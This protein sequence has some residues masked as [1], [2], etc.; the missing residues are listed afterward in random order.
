MKYLK[1]IKIVFIIFTIFEYFNKMKFSS[2]SYMPYIFWGLF[3]VYALIYNYNDENKNINLISKI[4]AFFLSFLMFLS[5]YDAV[6]SSAE[7]WNSYASIF[8]I[9]KSILV[10]IGMY[11][12]FV[13]I[14]EYILKK[15]IKINILNNIIY[16]SKFIYYYVLFIFII[17]NLVYILAYFPGLLTADSISQVS[18]VISKNYS[19]HHPVFHTYLISF[20][21]SFFKNQQNNN[22]AVFAFC[23][24]QILVFIFIHTYAYYVL[25]KNKK[26]NI[27][28]I[29]LPLINVTI[30]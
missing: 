20:I 28:F 26:L 27:I 13:N 19:N 8:F 17:F 5:N 6:Y 16:D 25:K 23:E 3:G 9:I 29:I 12:L 2:A 4:G 22:L 7:K 11:V 24:M 18:Q 1:H 15:K 14:I 10:F 30:M 21:F